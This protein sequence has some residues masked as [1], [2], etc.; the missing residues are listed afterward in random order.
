MAKAKSKTSKIPSLPKKKLMLLMNMIESQFFE[1]NLIQCDLTPHDIIYQEGNMRV[2]HYRPLEEEEITLDGK[3]VPV[4]AN[5]YR[6]PVVMIPPLGATAVN[7]DL[8]PDRSIVKYLMANGFDVYLIDWG[9]V[10]RMESKQNLEHYIATWFPNALKAIRQDS[11][12]RKLSLVGYCMGG[13][14]SLMYVSHQN[15]RNIKNIV[16]IVAPLNWYENG[17]AGQLIQLVNKKAAIISGLLNIRLSK[18]PES[19]FHVPGWMLALIFKMTDPVGS[20]KSYFDGLVNMWDRD[21]L[22]RRK[23]MEQWFNKMEDYSGAMVRDVLTEYM[24][25]NKLASGKVKLG[26]GEIDLS[27]IDSPLLAFGGK[28]DNLVSLKAAEHLLDLVSS[29]DKEFHAV[30]GGHAGAFAGKKSFES[31]W[32]ITVKW[33]SK[34]SR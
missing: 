20:L 10:S 18:L 14:L 16:T 19:A 22:I 7:F 21:F 5:R 24:H 3:P 8:F 27:S 34:R 32:P 30:P 13:L 31:T 26:A 2:R 4:K 33:L 23:T 25:D 17:A 15:D 29:T 12:K 28:T 6:T 11:G 1:E 9:E